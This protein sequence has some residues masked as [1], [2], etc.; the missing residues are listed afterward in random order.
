MATADHY[1]IPVY[2]RGAGS[3]LVGGAVPV[4]S[5]IVLS[6]ERLDRIFPVNAVDRSVRVQ[7][8]VITRQINEQAKPYGLFYA[9]DPASSAISSIGGNIATNAG[10]FHCV[11]YGVTRDSVLSLTVVL[12]DGS[13]VHAGAGTIKDVAGLDMVSLFTGSEGTLAVVVEAVLRLRPLPQTTETI[14]AFFSALE[15]VGS[16]VTNIM[17]SSLQPSVFELMGV[18]EDINQ[19]PAFR[20]TGRDAVWMLVIQI[21]DGPSGGNRETLQRTLFDQAISVKH[22]DSAGVEWLFAR[23]RKGKPFPAGSW[24]L[25]ADIA[26]P[27]SKLVDTLTTLQGIARRHNLGYSI[28]A[29][30]GDGNLHITLFAPRQESDAEQPHALTE[31]HRELLDKTLAVGGT[32]TG[33]HGVGI[34]L[35]DVLVR[36]IGRRQLD[37]QRGIKNVLDPHGILNPGK[38]L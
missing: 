35:A 4:R 37:L 33:E 26:V 7:A 19:S 25:S 28:V 36:Q 20:D 29:H 11:K 3:G 2:V 38:W 9:P 17:Q 18:P 22:P 12:A 15:H 30:V 10:G 31:G 21:D 27:I 23:R 6:T 24:M 32:I 14:V 13:I 1:L 8:G 16:S 34:E 5:G